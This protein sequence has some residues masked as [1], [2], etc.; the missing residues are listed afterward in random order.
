MRFKELIDYSI[1][2]LMAPLVG[3]SGA[4]KVI[5]DG[6]EWTKMEELMPMEGGGHGFRTE[7]YRAAVNYERA[8]TGLIIPLSSSITRC[9]IT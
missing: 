6:G 8:G 2:V 4:I 7:L 5:D 9:G 1:F 3:V